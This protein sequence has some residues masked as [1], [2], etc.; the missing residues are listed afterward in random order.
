MLFREEDRTM[1]MS[2]VPRALTLVALAALVSTSASTVLAQQAKT[3]L[4][5]KAS[6]LVALS[7]NVSPGN[8]VP[9]Q[10]V[11]G[12]GNLTGTFVLS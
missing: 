8:T 12:T 2:H 11:D 4:G 10:E 3:H 5:G 7:A 6:G 1:Q 9:L